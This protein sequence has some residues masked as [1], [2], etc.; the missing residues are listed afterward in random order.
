MN[1]FVY[2]DMESKINRCRM[3]RRDE[4]FTDKELEKEIIQIDK[5][6]RNYHKVI[7]NLEWGDK[8][9]YHLCINTSHLEIKEIIPSLSGYIENWFKRR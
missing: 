4:K 7:S 5:N 1:L 2:A 3:K 9:N 8:R 6:R